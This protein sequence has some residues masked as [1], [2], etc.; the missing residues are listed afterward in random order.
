[1]EYI[2]KA[3]AW[4]MDW[5]H[6]FVPNYWLDIIIFTAITKVLQFPITLWCHVNSLKM[7]S[8]MPK[9]NRLKIQYFG[10]KDKIGEETAALFKKEHYH[11]L[12]SLLPLGIQ[13]VILMGFV[14]V[15]HGITDGDSTALLAQIP[16]RDGGVSW[17][18]PLIAG[19]A[20][21]FLGFCQNR[22][23]PLQHEQ[24]RAQQIVTNGISI[25][26]SLFLGC[27]VAMGVGLYWAASNI[28]SILTQL[29]CNVTIVPKTRIDYPELYKS[30]KELEDLEASTK[31][32]V[33]QEAKRREK[34]VY[35]RFFHI[36]NKHVVFYS[37]GS[38]F[39]KYF[40]SLINWLLSHSNLVIHYVTN[41]PKD[42]IFGIAAQQSRIKP[43]YIGPMTIIPLM[44]KMD[45]DMVVMT[46]P[47]LGK[48]QIKRSYVRKDVEYLYMTHGVSSVHLC[49]RQGAFDN[50]DTIFVVGPYQI[51]EHR[52]TEEIY[53]LKAKNL[54]KS[55]YMLLDTLFAQYERDK[56]EIAARKKNSPAKILIAPSYHDG[57]ILESCIDELIAQCCA[58]GRQVVV[59]PHP[60]FI[61]HQPA[62]MQAILAKYRDRPESE[63]KFE[64]D[65]K[66]N[67]SIYE[68][69]IVVS[70]W[71][72]I[73]YEFSFTTK[74]PCVIIDTP[75]KVINPEWK[76]LGIEP[77]DIWMRD[78]V[79][80][81]VRMDALNTVNGIVEDMLA[82]PDKFADKIQA[83]MDKTLYNPGHSGEVAGKYILETLIN[84]KKRSG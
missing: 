52:K 43:Y 83:L 81:L 28:F 78:G 53:K 42:Q 77:A 39:Y 9:T 48:Y 63:L 16:V 84:K 10:D 61:T 8:L 41:D 33:S 31:V 73:S 5:L 17:S 34:E 7:V 13:I 51:D 66:S 1:M 15:I 45:A 11:P 3:F 59:R 79:G 57:N 23:N 70:D 19:A 40:E 24:T 36:A 49:L 50:Y 74:K 2:V 25:G 29:W 47:D 56:A 54:I 37:E 46:T 27:Y 58:P 35:K 4:M 60:R 14:K 64:M 82:H 62:K 30:K 32:V 69:D 22:I 55:G 71:S 20:A 44:M 68:S 38:G 76:R 80:A 72:S 18:M 75:M 12:L 6:Q 65:F 67:S 26:I 21:W